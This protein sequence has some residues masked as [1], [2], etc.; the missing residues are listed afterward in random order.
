MTLRGPC[1]SPQQVQQVLRDSDASVSGPH[2]G[3]QGYGPGGS[4]GGGSLLLLNHGLTVP[5]PGPEGDQPRSPR[6]PGSVPGAAA[7]LLGWAVSVLGSLGSCSRHRAQGAVFLS[8]LC[9]AQ[10]AEPLHWS[11]AVDAQAP[12]AG[13]GFSKGSFEALVHGA[14]GCVNAN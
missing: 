12:R 9:E 6:A 14:R 11:D 10:G 7:L 1:A 5:P 4:H 2:R 13:G 8:I 3:E